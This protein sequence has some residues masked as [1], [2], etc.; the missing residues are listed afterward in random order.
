MAEEELRKENAGLQIELHNL[1]EVFSRHRITQN[2]RLVDLENRLKTLEQRQGP[3]PGT[4]PK[5][6]ECKAINKD[7]V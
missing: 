2:K 4:M 5:Y 3:I 6:F 1:R 7:N